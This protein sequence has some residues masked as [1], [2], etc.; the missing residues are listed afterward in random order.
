MS[1]KGMGGGDGSLKL[2]FPAKGYYYF[3]LRKRFGVISSFLIYF[4]HNNDKQFTN[5]VISYLVIVDGV[6]CANDMSKMCGCNKQFP[7]WKRRYQ[8]VVW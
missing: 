3:L 7:S 2:L 1:E 8:R 4:Q 5:V 6:C